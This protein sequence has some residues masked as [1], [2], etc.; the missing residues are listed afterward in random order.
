MK[1]FTPMLLALLP[2]ALPALAKGGMALQGTISDVKVEG[3]SLS[4]LFTG[5][6]NLEFATAPR[7]Q[8]QQMVEWQVEKVPVRACKWTNPY[9][10]QKLHL[11]VTFSNAVLRARLRAKDGKQTGIGIYQPQ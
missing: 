4:F 11:A 6:I 7:A 10:G 3:E 8:K 2:L 9:D 5:R 1:R